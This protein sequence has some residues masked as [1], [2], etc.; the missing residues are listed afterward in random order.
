MVIAEFV[1]R[2]TPLDEKYVINSLVKD[3]NQTILRP[4]ELTQLSVKN[5]VR[6]NNTM[7]KLPDIKNGLIKG[8]NCV[9]AQTWENILSHIE[10]K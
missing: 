4:I 3:N 7:Y 5:Y 6:M 2:L 8:I 9:N 1:K 10:K